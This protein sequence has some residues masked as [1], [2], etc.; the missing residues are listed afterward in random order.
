MIEDIHGPE[1][2]IEVICPAEQTL[3]QILLRRRR[4]MKQYN[5]SIPAEPISLAPS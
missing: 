2:C 1:F 5:T 4:F 3:D